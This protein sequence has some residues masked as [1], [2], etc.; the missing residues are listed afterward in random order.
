[1]SCHDINLTRK[2]ESPPLVL[3]Q[4]YMFRIICICKINLLEPLNTLAIFKMGKKERFFPFSFWCILEFFIVDSNSTIK[5]NPKPLQFSFR[6]LCK[7]FWLKRR[8]KKKVESFQASFFF[9][10]LFLSNFPIIVFNIYFFNIYTS[11]IFLYPLPFHLSTTSLIF[12]PLL[13]FHL[14]I[15]LY[16]NIILSLSHHF[17][18]FLSLL[19]HTL[20]L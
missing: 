19:I 8:K 17:P 4:N 18:L 20:L 12:L 16:I 3:Y 6:V 9:L 1:M 15:A 10:N 13:L 11:P 7:P 2:H 14:P 5:P